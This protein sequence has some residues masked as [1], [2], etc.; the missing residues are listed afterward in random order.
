MN[1]RILLAGLALSTVLA[2]PAFAQDLK[3]GMAGPITG[4]N[5]AFG[6]QLSDG[7]AQASLISTPRA[8]SSAASWCWSPVMTPPFLPRVCQ[9]PTR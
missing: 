1:R 5:A 4:P 3:I 8:A 2:G 7:T 9:S 6:K